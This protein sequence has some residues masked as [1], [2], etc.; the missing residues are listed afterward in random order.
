[1]LAE[2]RASAGRHDLRRI[3]QGKQR[4]LLDLQEML[5]TVFPLDLGQRLLF[6]IPDQVIRINKRHLHFLRKDPAD[7]ALATSWHTYQNYHF[8]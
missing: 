6:P 4:I 1:M 7:C 8:L 3:I 5:H 2:H